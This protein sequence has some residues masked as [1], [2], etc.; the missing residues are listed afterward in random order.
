MLCLP[1][2]HTAKEIELNQENLTQS[3]ATAEVTVAAVTIGD[4]RSEKQ[5]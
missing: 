5:D 4:I 3:L 2:L 1:F